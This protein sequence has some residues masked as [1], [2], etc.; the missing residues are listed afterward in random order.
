MRLHDEQRVPAVRNGISALVYT[1][2]SDVEEEN[3][4]LVTYDKRLVKVDES[5]VRGVNARIAYAFLE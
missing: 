5:V 1:Q 2:L 3:N 4:G